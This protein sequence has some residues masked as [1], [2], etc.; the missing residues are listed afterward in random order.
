MGPRSSG[1]GQLTLSKNRPSSAT[2]SLRPDE[3]RPRRLGMDAR[4]GGL[5]RSVCGF[6]SIAQLALALTLLAALFVVC[7]WTPDVIARHLRRGRR[8]VGLPAEGARQ[9][10]SAE[11][12]EHAGFV[13]AHRRCGATRA[14]HE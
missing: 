11:R 4:I 3:L 5:C 12:V 7:G 1:H 10:R 6:L 2:A 8:A 13:A 9:H 14:M